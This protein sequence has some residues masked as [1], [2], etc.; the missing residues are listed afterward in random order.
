MSNFTNLFVNQKSGKIETIGAT[1][2]TALDMRAA[3]ARVGSAEMPGLDTNFFV[4]GSVESKASGS[5]GVS[6]FGGDVVISGSLYGGSPLEMRSP[7]EAYGGLTGSLTNL[8]DGSSYITAA[9]QYIVITTGSTGQIQIG[10]TLPDPQYASITQTND[11]TSLGTDAGSGNER[12]LFN[13]S[14]SGTTPTTQ[15]NGTNYG[16]VYTA[17]TGRFTVDSG[18]DYI[19]TVVFAAK[20]SAT[21]QYDVRIKVNGS[22]KFTRRNGTETS[23]DPDESSAS[24]ILT[25]AAGDYV[26]VTYEDDGTADIFPNDGSTL[27]MYK[28]SGIGSSGWTDDGTVVR[29]KTATDKVGIGDSDP[30]AF[31]TDVFMYVSGSSRGEASGVT[32]FGGDVIIS[33]TLHGGSPLKIAGA[34]LKLGSNEIKETATGKMSFGGLFVDDG[35]L[36]FGDDEETGQ[37]FGIDKSVGKIKVGSMHFDDEGILFGDERFGID[38]SNNKLKIGSMH[39]DDQGILFGDERFGIDANNNKLKIGAMHFDDQGILFGAER[40]GVDSNNN[41][42][43]GQVAFDADGLVIGN[44]KIKEENGS[45]KFDASDILIG[46]QKLGF[47]A[48]ALMMGQEVNQAVKIG[49]VRVLGNQLSTWSEKPLVLGAGYDEYVVIENELIVT[50]TSIVVGSFHVSDCLVSEANDI[51][52]SLTNLFDGTSFL[53]A[54]DGI[55]IVSQSN[56]SVMI[57]QEGGSGI[58]AAE[59]GTYND[60]LFSD[61]TANTSVGTAVDRFNEVLKSLA[62][63]PAPNM[64][65]ITED[66]SG[67]SAKL[68][69]GP[70]L[71]VLPYQDVT[72]IGSLSAGDVNSE[73]AIGAAGNDRRVGVIDGSTSITGKINNS[74]AA[75]ANNYVADAFGSAD[76][77]LL[78]LELNGSE[79]IVI[80]LTQNSALTG[81]TTNGSEL[82]ITEPYPSHFSDGTELDIFKHRTGLYEIKSSDMVPGYNFARIIQ[83]VGASDTVTNYLDWVVDPLP[84]PVVASNPVLKNLSLTGDK[85]LSGVSYYTGGTVEHKVYIDNAYKNVY[86]NSA[87]ALTFNGT[88]CSISYVSPATGYLPDISLPSEDQNKSLYV[89]G[90]MNITSNKLLGENV[91]SSVNVLHPISGKS[92]SSGG[93][94]TVPD[95]LVYNVADT[96]TALNETFTGESYRLPAASYDYQID[97]DNFWDSSETLLIN[98]GLLIYNEYLVPPTAGINAGDFSSVANGP[99]GNVDYAGIT[100]GVR[101]Y[102]RKFKNNSGGSKTNFAITFSGSGAVAPQGT[103]IAGNSKFN[104]SFKLPTNSENQSTGWMDLALPFSTG[105]TSDGDGCL[106]GTLNGMGSSTEGTFGTQFL[107]DN[108]YLVMK[109]EADA[110]WTGNINSISL[111]WV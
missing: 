16:V 50:G 108:D 43:I 7:V 86:S 1:K 36:V 34:G 58:G 85:K 49:D 19:V 37:R 21:T 24:V 105:Q 81:N 5:F 20:V 51:T 8:L 44:Q 82:N 78:I 2:I 61:F 27:T 102:Y 72:G 84:I 45:L 22:T 9:D 10:T 94:V 111:S 33:G 107:S 77:G 80:D 17:S 18:G 40:F 6:V 53:V 109:I 55:N 38:V 97:V 30:A 23:G 57:A 42:K 110:S 79:V 76:S 35:A 75:D 48:G 69:F 98:D 39:F 93:S 54:G 62:P 89:E 65:E 59:D 52:G 29:L 60:G 14:E 70:A 32:V 56:G 67:N 47:E 101:T 3:T 106:V 73:F 95:L 28:I 92:L 12:I 13:T 11:I 83:R 99:V 46:D 64:S 88:N 25:L 66:Q 103:N 90:L 41:L 104:V 15:E 96:A 26:T 71:P 91:T 4:S 68:S 87:S 31:G 100:S 74:V 63:S